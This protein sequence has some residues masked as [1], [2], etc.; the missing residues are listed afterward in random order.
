MCYKLCFLIYPQQSWNSDVELQPTSSQG[1]LTAAQNTDLGLPES[2]RHPVAQK[3]GVASKQ[4]FTATNSRSKRN[5]SAF[6][7]FHNKN[8]PVKFSVS[9]EWALKECQ[10]VNYNFIQSSSNAQIFLRQSLSICV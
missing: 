7:A 10:V 2:L 9:G 1:N 4:A 8:A 5:A 6:P 3:A